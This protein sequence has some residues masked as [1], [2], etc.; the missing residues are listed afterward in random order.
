MSRLL[1]HLADLAGHR[2]RDALDEA[3]M[4]LIDE[5]I[6]PQYV[7]I[8]RTVGSLEAPRWLTHV[9]KRHRGEQRRGYDATRDAGP[10]VPLES[11]PHHLTCLQ[12][13]EIVRMTQAPAH[14]LYPLQ[15]DSEIVAVLEVWQLNA[16]TQEE[17]RILSAVRRYYRHLRGLLDENERDALTGLLNRK[18]FDETFVR[19]ALQLGHDV[20]APLFKADER[21]RPLRN[22][23]FWLGVVDIDNFKRIN[24]EFGHLMGDEVLLLLGQIMRHSFRHE[25]HLYRFGGEEF[26]VLLSGDRPVDARQALERLRTTVE[27]H[28]F[29]RVGSLTVSIGYTEL[30]PGDTPSAA[31]ERADQAVYQAKRDGRNCSVDFDK[32]SFDHPLAESANTGMVEFF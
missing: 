21:R 19:A 10:T 23:R 20:P 30:Q 29:P 16:P 14:W 8:H 24:D 15:T 26:L 12:S 6:C 22:T 5:L 13:G 7:A 4:G 25:E 32:L 28:A 9:Y 27:S 2:D 11:L 3:V 18:S 31:F 1:D 17:A